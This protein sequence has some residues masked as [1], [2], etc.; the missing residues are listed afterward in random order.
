MNMGKSIDIGQV[1]LHK[2]VQG[3]RLKK[4]NP[5]MGVAGAQQNRLLS[6][7]PA[8]ILVRLSLNMELVFDAAR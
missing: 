2:P 8:E 1:N 7:L 4:L 5:E 3:F 6:V